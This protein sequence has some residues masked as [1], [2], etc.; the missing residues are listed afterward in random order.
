VFHFRDNRLDEVR[1]VK[2]NKIVK[3]YNRTAWVQPVI[4]LDSMEDDEVDSG[5]SDEFLENEDTFVSKIVKHWSVTPLSD[6]EF[7]VTLT[8]ESFSFK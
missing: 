6:Y 7:I 5:F 8:Q 3:S 1:F 2:D 4:D